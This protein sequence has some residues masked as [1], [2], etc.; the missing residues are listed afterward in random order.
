MDRLA[1]RCC[2]IDKL[3][4]SVMMPDAANFVRTVSIDQGT[5][6]ERLRIVS[7]ALEPSSYSLSASLTVKA[8]Y[9]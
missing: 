1:K 7:F 5:L 9:L 4:G 3:N 6:H 2:H 8:D